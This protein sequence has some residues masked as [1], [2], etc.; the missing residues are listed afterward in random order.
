[1]TLI[2]TINEDGSSL[3]PFLSPMLNS[4][5]DAAHAA[6]HE[7]KMTSN[8]KGG[9]SHFFKSQALLDFELLREHQKE[10]LAQASSVATTPRGSRYGEEARQQ[11][12]HSLGISSI[13]CYSEFN[14]SGFKRWRQSQT[15]AS[16]LDDGRGG[17][18]T[19]NLE[20]TCE[21]DANQ[22]EQLPRPRPHQRQLGPVA[23]L[24]RW[25]SKRATQFA[26]GYPRPE[27]IPDAPPL[28][29]A[30][31][32][33]VH[34]DRG[35]AG[36]GGRSGG[37]IP[38][39]RPRS[40][41]SRR[42]ASTTNIPVYT[43]CLGAQLS[44][45]L[46]L[47][48]TTEAGGMGGGHG[49]QGT[50]GGLASLR[51]R[52]ASSLAS[53]GVVGGGAGARYSSWDEGLPPRG[54]LN[55]APDPVISLQE[56]TEMFEEID[57]VP[58][59]VTRHDVS[60]AF[61]AALASSS[62]HPPLPNQLPCC[63]VRP[64]EL[65]YPAFQDVLIRLALAAAALDEQHRVMTGVAAPPPSSLLPSTPVSPGAAVHSLMA[66]MGLTSPGTAALKRRLDAL[67]RMS[68]DRAQHKS[69]NKFKYISTGHGMSAAKTLLPPVEPT[70]LFSRHGTG[71]TVD[72]PEPAPQSLVAL[73]LHNDTAAERRY[74]PEWRPFP[75]QQA[76]SIHMG[77]MRV[78][79]LRSFRVLLRNRG[80]YQMQI[81]VDATSS[82]FSRE[83][84]Y[85][86]GTGDVLN[87][88]EGWSGPLALQ[89]GGLS[90]SFSE[91]PLPAGVP[92]VLE[93]DAR[94]EVPGE[95]SGEIRILSYV[96]QDGHGQQRVNVVPWYVEVLGGGGGQGR[97][98]GAAPAADAVSGGKGECQEAEWCGC[99]RC[100][101][102]R[103]I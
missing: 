76:S 103:A 5:V 34:V 19:P 47:A 15:S 78:G 8:D 93:V 100:K 38:C 59:M 60:E 55:R 12:R 35:G 102:P 98:V 82:S 90:C 77:S 27:D 57:V 74:Q 97:L 21:F 9:M 4:I 86:G 16:W 56:L 18:P 62:F 84:S 52:I 29:P 40:A 101:A 63:Q 30:D 31:P 69:V 7:K 80:T 39:S 37:L 64:D 17:E 6:H 87:G 44:T 32:A 73:L 92:R 49:A 25:F 72:S 81:H 48:S 53:N 42:R 20:V 61:R 94:F 2:S 45:M 46:H 65:R 58:S 10:L 11:R 99:P 67:A 54:G 22:L 28:P 96:K 26:P 36:L 13:G 51:T 50:L 23:Y 95:Y 68:G 70:G 89:P 91:L 43:P 66:R 83:G 71:W 75:V 14:D 85:S 3:R 33:H 41:T 88:G 1:M 79:E 24:F